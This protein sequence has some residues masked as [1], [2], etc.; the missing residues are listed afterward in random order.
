MANVNEV[1][2][3]GWI[4]STF[5]EWGTW[6]NE[7]IDST[8]VEKDTFAMWWLGCTGLWIKTENDTNI[9]I[10]YWCGSG[11]R[12]HAKGLI[13]PNH[14]MARMCGGVK[15]QPNLRA[16]PA[17]LDPFALTKLNA[18][19]ASHT[20]TDH[21]DINLAAA[22]LNN[23]KGQ[24][25]M[26]KIN[27]GEKVEREIPFIGSLYA[28]TMWKNWGVPEDRLITVRPGDI[29]EVNDIKVHAVESYDRTI[30]ITDPP[31]GVGELIENWKGVMTDDMDD[32]A[33]SYVIETPAGTIYHSGDSHYSNG[34]AKHGNQYKINVAFGSYGE[35]PRGVTDKMTSSDILR[36]GEALNTDVMIPY[37]HDLW[38]NFDA[39]TNEILVL[40]HMRKNRLQYKFKP[41]IWRVGGK[42]VWPNDKD[43]L[44]YHYPRGFEDCF[45]KEI[46]LPYPSFL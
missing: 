14:Q 36:M 33:V 2:R 9:A 13:S 34:Y 11:K 8:V 23:L 22:V 46:N 44:E 37:H 5:P 40:W 1:T 30:L 32:R 25:S 21:I 43:N 27:D 18:V 31:A 12:T 28:T 26:V 29:I 35:N 15:M 17:V 20:H 4:L 19:L 41:F 6:L 42:F 16:V 3:E 38:T 45:T 10:D 24:T 39:D 7:E